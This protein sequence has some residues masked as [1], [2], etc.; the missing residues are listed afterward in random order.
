MLWAVAALSIDG[1]F[2]PWPGVVCG[3]VMIGLLTWLRP[4]RYAL[5][6]NGLIIAG[7][8]VW[9]FHLTPSNERGWQP[10]VARLP[11]AQLDGHM[12][13]IENVRDFRY[14]GAD[15]TDF[16]ER[17]ETRRYDLSKI[18][19]L[20][21]YLSNWGP[22]HIAHT[23][24]SWRFADGPPLAI[25]IETRKERGESYSALLGFFRQYEL[26]YVVADERDV[27]GVRTGHRGE[28]MRLYAIAGQREGAR[29]LLMGYIEDINA[30]A[31]RPRWYNAFT[32][33]CTTVIFDNVLHVFG[34]S[35]LWD[36]RLY[37][38]AHLPEM[39]YEEGFVDTDMSYAELQERS[40][41]TATARAADGA[42]DFSRRIRARL[43]AVKMR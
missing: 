16:E 1:E 42:E 18:V 41:I 37:A 2:A 9:W 4:F 21:I 28:T 5:L 31:A 11:R 14:H 32:T 30:L 40:D 3:L 15:D 29:R 17:W 39:L 22:K 24:M 27:I 19:G 43:P 34:V 7:V 38:N 6:A 8:L 26:Y 12:L 23:I 13:T 35:K 10:D 33:N 36:W 25:S 20:D